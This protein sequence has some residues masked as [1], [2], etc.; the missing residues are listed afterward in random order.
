M[1][2]KSLLC[3]AAAL[4]LAAWAADPL[5]AF[6]GDAKQSSV[7]GLSSGAFMAAQYQVAYSAS[8]VG[9]GVVAGGPYYCA[10]GSLPG[11]VAC[12]AG[13]P[14]QP[15]QLLASAKQFAAAGR[16]DPLADLAKRRVYLF[17]GTQDNT[18]RT[19]V[20]DAA[21]S[22]FQLAGV[23]AAQIAYQK[24]LPAGHAQITPA[25]GND[26][27]ATASPYINHCSW[28]GQGYDQAGLILQHIYGAL[29]AKASAL[30]GRIV[31][32]NQKPYAAAGSSLADEGFVYVPRAC[33]EGEACKVHIALHG[34]QQYAGKV[35]DAFYAHAGYNNWADSNRILVLYP[36]TTTSAANPQGC[37]DWFGY[38]GPAYAWK[39]GLQMRAL[40]A[41]ADRL[42]SAP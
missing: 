20:V 22:F 4:P 37:W 41:M 28:Q 17:S 35:G 6:H 23:P 25:Y 5:P 1:K 27:G 30:T 10:Q 14:P 24:Q 8:V 36:Q 40:K 42:V 2:L 19:P 18:V 21:A 3:L 33:A 7:S 34:C 31:R 12:M 16:I 15:A 39:S 11:T 32:F 38:T 29:Q 13:P 9:A 26:C